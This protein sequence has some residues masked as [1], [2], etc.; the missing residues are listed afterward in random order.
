MVIANKKK[1]KVVKP[2]TKEKIGTIDN[3]TPGSSRIRLCI[4][5]LQFR[6]TRI[7]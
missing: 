1:K 7:S 6:S 5:V 3:F 4:A 2:S